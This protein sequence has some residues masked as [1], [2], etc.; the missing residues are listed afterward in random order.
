MLYII[1]DI[2]III[3]RKQKRVFITFIKKAII[4]VIKIKNGGK[5]LE[6]P[7]RTVKT[8][9]FEFLYTF[10]FLIFE[11]KNFKINYYYY[12]FNFN[13]PGKKFSSRVFRKAK[14]KK[15]KKKCYKE[16]EGGGKTCH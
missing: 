8:T 9:N 15:F 16:R 14:G 2:I 3:I 1:T 13:F 6:K 5:V 12:Y 10:F 7:V 11:I 4:I